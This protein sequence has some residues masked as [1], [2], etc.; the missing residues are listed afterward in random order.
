MKRAIKEKMWDPND[1]RD[2]KDLLKSLRWKLDYYRYNEFPV[3]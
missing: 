1:I 3:G 2:L